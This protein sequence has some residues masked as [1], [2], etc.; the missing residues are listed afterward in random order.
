[1]VQWELLLQSV[2]FALQTSSGYITTGDN[3]ILLEKEA[4]EK[5]Y[6]N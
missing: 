4:L 3:R 1:M 2:L 5:K 6:K